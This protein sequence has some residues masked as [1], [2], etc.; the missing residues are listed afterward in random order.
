MSNAYA[1]ALEISARVIRENLADP[2]TA[3]RL[4]TE[5]LHGVGEFANG[6]PNDYV[7]NMREGFR[8]VLAGMYGIAQRGEK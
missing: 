5:R 4:I 6:Q 2:A 8:A 3:R 1:S 7:E